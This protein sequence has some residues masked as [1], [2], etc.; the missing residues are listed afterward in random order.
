[1][2]PDH[3]RTWNDEADQRLPRLRLEAPPPFAHAVLGAAAQ[4]GHEP[5]AVPL[6]ILQLARL[7]RYAPTRSRPRRR[8]RQATTGLPWTFLFSTVRPT[9]DELTRSFRDVT[10]R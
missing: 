10:N 1:M 3:Y 7:D 6:P 9:R 2:A 4:G 5:A 8:C